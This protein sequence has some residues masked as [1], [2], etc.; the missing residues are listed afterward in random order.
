MSSLPG[1]YLAGLWSSDVHSG[2]LWLREMTTARHVPTYR[3]PSWSWAA[4]NERIQF[5][6]DRTELWREN[7]LAAQLVAHAITPAD[8]T[9]PYGEVRAGALTLRGLTRPLV[10]SRQV[11]QAKASRR[12]YDV[13]FLDETEEGQLHSPDSIFSVG[14]GEDQHLVAFYSTFGEPDEEVEIDPELYSPQQLMLL[15][16]QRSTSFDHF[17][18]LK[19]VNESPQGNAYERVGLA[20]ADPKTS[21]ELG[22]W[23]MQTVG[24]I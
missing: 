8:S 9:N 19:L 16:I 15:Y 12:S 5:E 13:L 1:E 7:P 6:T 11:I 4:T 23:S 22:K 20:R 3:A 24:L 10:C 14:N 21:E 18:V 2:L 17:L